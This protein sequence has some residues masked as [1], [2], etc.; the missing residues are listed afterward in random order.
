MKTKRILAVLLTLA[1][2]IGMLPIMANAQ[3]AEVLY[4]ESADSLT[5]SGMLESAFNSSSAKYIKLQSNVT[6]TS[7][8][9]LWEGEKTVDLNGYTI[10][11][12]ETSNAFYIFQSTLNL[13]DTSEGTKGKV[14]SSVH[15]ITLEYN[16]AL[17]IGNSTE[18]SGGFTIETKSESLP[19]IYVPS[20][21]VDVNVYQPFTVK[22]G[23]VALE[24]YG[25]FHG[26][27]IPFD[28]KGGITNAGTI[29]N[30]N[31]AGYVELNS[32]IY[33]IAG[34]LH[35]TGGTYKSKNM[36][37]IYMLGGEVELEGGTF[38]SE[39]GNEAIYIS[40]SAGA[41]YADLLGE[42]CYY[43]DGESDTEIRREEALASAR[44]LTV[45][46][47]PTPTYA[48]SVTTADG[49]TSYHTDINDAIGAAQN[50][51][52]STLKLLD[53]IVT[54]AQ[55]SI[56]GGSF[57]I[58]LNGKTWQRASTILSFSNDANITITDSS[59]EGTG[60]LLGTSSSTPTI[61]FRDS[62]KLEIAGGTVENNA[63]NQA[64]D[65]SFGGN[66]TNAQ[67]IVSGGKVLSSGSNAI[68][69]HGASVTVTGGAIESTEGG[70]FYR[71][72]IIDLS[73]HI[74]PADITIQARSVLTVGS[75]LLLPVGYAMWDGSGN[76]VE[77]FSGS[78][79]YTV[80][81]CD[82]GGDNATYDNGIC[83]IC[84]YV[85]EHN[86]FEGDKCTV[87]G[88]VLEN[89]IVEYDKDTK[90]AIVTIK[91]AGTYSLIFAKYGEGNRI[92][93]IDIVEF[94]FVQGENT[95]PQKLTNFTLGT[96]DKVMLWKDMTSLVP[97]C[98]AYIVK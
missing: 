74:A 11:A 21:S 64:V 47:T 46:V 96:G 13:I 43:T 83:T 82:H 56:R 22:G 12:P 95:V 37:G 2:I 88:Y 38:E 78:N 90:S 97:L 44:K 80:G 58:D 85:C 92:N 62:A 70:I 65:M 36:N 67:L 4:G 18:K 51:E 73:R 86:T 26:N 35:I 6:L 52:D 77:N 63:G 55:V 31:A 32:T 14:V 39:S 3:T 17:N 53:N 61:S 7:C 41:T 29:S 19:A 68:I 81:E 9:E 15:S 71:T 84:G 28:F 45:A 23:Y 75:T 24:N 42:G 69:A 87:C 10:T 49:A 50:S 33:I 34:S 72:G 27:N 48:A 1:M 66:K 89:T 79:T 60:K 57:T 91:E 25:N 94:T 40:S 59:I 98:E 20:S 16:G 54:T 30:L 93:K 8:L 76:V 5:S